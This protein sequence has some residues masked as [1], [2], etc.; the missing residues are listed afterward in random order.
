MKINEAGLN[1]V[2]EKEGLYLTSYPDIESELGRA[3]KAKGIKV[4]NNEYKKLVG[5]EKL[6]ASPVTIGYGS[7]GPDIKLGMVWTKA[8]SEARLLLKMAEFEKGVTDRIKVPLTSNQFSALCSFCYNL[9]MGP[10]TEGSIDDK[11]NVKDFK[12]ATDTM[13][14]Y[15]KAGK[16]PVVLAGLTKRRQLEVALFQKT[17][18]PIAPVKNS[19]VLGNGPSEDDIRKMLSDVESKILSK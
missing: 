12:A 14:L 19:G 13:L 2:K 5:W 7:T 18:A 8:Q 17:E 9:G 6:D 1:L 4:Y 15:N 11:L 10:L 16:P 3:C